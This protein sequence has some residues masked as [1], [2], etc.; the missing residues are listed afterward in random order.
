MDSTDKEVLKK[1]RK[2]ALI[3]GFGA[4]VILQIITYCIL[5]TI[6]DPK[7]RLV[8]LA[9]SVLI[10]VISII[11]IGKYRQKNRS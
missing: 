8:A 10:L 2:T 9:I 7:G 11:I 1:N 5:K 6:N 4:I 3:L